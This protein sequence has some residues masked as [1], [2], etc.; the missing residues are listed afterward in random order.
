MQPALRVYDAVWGGAALATPDG[1]AAE[2]RADH[3]A[4]GAGSSDLLPR[5]AQMVDRPGHF[6]RPAARARRPSRG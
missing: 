3:P 6:V 2:A 5:R 1:A 4:R